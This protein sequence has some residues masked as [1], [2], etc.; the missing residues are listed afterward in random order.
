MASL[1]GSVLTITGGLSV[2]SSWVMPDGG[3]A[4]A[5]TFTKLWGNFTTNAMLPLW[6][7]RMK[8]TLLPMDSVLTNTATAG[9]GW[10]LWATIGLLLLRWN[11]S[12]V[13]RRG[14][15]TTS[16]DAPKTAAISDTPIDGAEN[17]SRRRFMAEALGG[18]AAVSVV[19]AGTFVTPWS[20]KVAR[21]TVPIRDLP[22]ELDGLRAVQISDTHLGA[23]VP[24]EHIQ[25]SVRTAMDLRPDI[26][27]LTG[28]YVLMGPQFIEGGTRVFAPLVKDTN[29]MGVVAVRGNHDHYWG[30]GEIAAQL[31][32][33]G[34]R[35]IDNTRVFVNSARKLIAEKPTVGLCVAGVGDLLEGQIDIHA[36]IGDVAETMPRVVL[37][38]NPQTAEFLPRRSVGPVPRID[39]MLSGHMHGGQ[40]KL[41]L[42]GSPWNSSPYWRKYLYGRVESPVG[43]VIVSAGV[44]LS[45]LPL[46]IGVP[47]EI[48]E[49]TLKRA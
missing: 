45:A 19:G 20:L 31:E 42:I 41:P 49:I 4:D 2:R 30:A 16:A 8:I 46:R 36:A 39:L 11:D 23:W 33:I 15:V 40:V 3:A 14:S 9:I 24:L 12:A 37:A 21:Y 22:P 32:A 13:R 47:C 26:Y 25:R 29:A 1:L 48:V 38:H 28:D 43:P 27:L 44:G 18:A 35:V 17:P 10:G 5:G 34:I 7:G 6:Y